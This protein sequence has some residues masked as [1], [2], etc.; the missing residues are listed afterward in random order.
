MAKYLNKAAWSNRGSPVF[1][2]LLC[3]LNYVFV[4]TDSLQVAT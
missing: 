4:F 3:W 2:F 1:C